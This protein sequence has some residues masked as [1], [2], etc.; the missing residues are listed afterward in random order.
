MR[1]IILIVFALI[2]SFPQQGHS[3]NSVNNPIKNF[4]VLWNTF[5]ERYANFDLKKV[6]WDEVYKRYRPLVS[7]TTTDRELFELS[8][9]MV[10]ELSDGHVG[11]EPN[12]ENSDIDCGP[13]YS[14]VYDE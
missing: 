14:F 1:H 9:S 5:N 13:P 12:F 4:E 6:D 10:Q 8:C 2:L 3:Q 11:I 7:A